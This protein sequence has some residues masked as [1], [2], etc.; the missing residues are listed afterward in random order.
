MTEL[1]P[2]QNLWLTETIRLREEH[3]GPLDDLEANRLA[4]AAGG[5]LPSRI[6]RRALWLAE[7]DGLTAA[8]KHWLQGARLAL[9]LLMIFAVLSG[10]GLAFAAL[11]QTPVN[12][13]WALGSLLGINLIL[14]LSWALGLI[15]A[16]EHGAT[17]GRLWLWLSEKFARDAKAAQLAPALLLLLQR[18]K[19]NRWALGALV[20]GLWLLAMLSALILLLTLMATRR[21]GFV[22]E[23]TILGADTFIHV[24]QALG[25][26]PSLLGF[27]VPTEE[28]IRASGAGALD[29][30]SARQAWA[31]WLVGVLV[32]YGVLP[33]LLLAL[34]CLWRW[35]RGKAAL[36]LDLNLPGYAQLRER[37]MPTSERL[38]VNDP[39]PA[40][41]HRIESNVGE[42]ASEG[43]LLVAIELDEQRPWPPVLPKNVSNAGI[44][45][46]RESRHKLLEQLS[47]F[48][49]AR[50]AIACDPRRSP[51]R[52]SLA[53]IAELAR[54]AS[55][56]RI[57][58]LQ[59]PPGEALDGQRLGDWHAALQQLE[60]PFADCAPMNWLESGHD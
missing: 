26:L 60:L 44:L 34:F 57:W 51:D 31:T 43:A 50:L 10:A 37:L 8:L 20:N 5:D 46:S 32:V 12:V 11:G 14:L 36:R 9:V 47:R 41:L 15:F 21:Y 7:R 28:M 54:N 4:R 17:L 1:T 45:D 53:L 27:N 40:Q 3:A 55:A 48:P 25:Y 2:L 59:A 23:T 24:T 38:G 52:G 6:A 18:K 49:P 13:F 29:N 30:E 42:R 39:E 33:R 35:N 22:W 58:L 19:L 56:T 16:G